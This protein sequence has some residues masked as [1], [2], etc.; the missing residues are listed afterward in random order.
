MC[1]AVEIVDLVHI[2]HAGITA[3]P[4][5][6]TLRETEPVALPVAEVQLSKRTS[7]KDI[8]IS[9]F[10]WHLSFLILLSASLRVWSSSISIQRPLTFSCPKLM[11]LQ[12]VWGLT[13][14]SF[15][16]WDNREK[17]VVVVFLLPLP[18]VKQ[19]IW[20]YR[21]KAWHLER[22]RW[23]WKGVEERQS[24]L[25]TRPKSSQDPLL[26]KSSRCTWKLQHMHIHTSAHWLCFLPMS[27]YS[28]PLSPVKTPCCCRRRSQASQRWSLEPRQTSWPPFLCPSSLPHHLH[29]RKA[30][31]P[32]WSQRC[33]QCCQTGLMFSNPKTAQNP[34]RLIIKNTQK[35]SRINYTN[36]SFDSSKKNVDH[37]NNSSGQL[38]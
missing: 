32:V 16:L 38:H 21:G 34:P 9:D 18:F 27:D 11:D 10:L 4:D 13:T 2:S 22:K 31:D 36:E 12:K 6:I 20:R 1:V 28:P 3:P 14:S 7:Y 24:R 15:L 26:S 5:T 33:Q 23:R 35:W 19:G 37:H 25:K 29:Q 30:K 17:V 8:G